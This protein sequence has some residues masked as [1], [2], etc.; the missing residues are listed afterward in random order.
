MDKKENLYEKFVKNLEEKYGKW[1]DLTSSFGHTKFG[2]IAEDLCVSSSQ[3][4]KLISGGATEGTYIRAIK[5][6]EQLK[7]LDSLKEENKSL[8]KE[9]D[10]LIATLKKPAIDKSSNLKYWILATLI[11]F[12]LGG[13]IVGSFLDEQSSSPNKKSNHFNHP[14]SKFFDKDFLAD[15]DSPYLNESEVQKYCPCSGYEGKWE[16]ASNYYFP[17][18]GSRKPGVYY[19]AKEGDIRLKCAKIMNPSKA[20]TNLIG[21]ERLLHEIWVDKRKR[22]FIP[23][24]FDPQSMTYTEA[25]KNL[26]FDTNPDFEKVAYIHSFFVDQFTLSSDSIYR[27]GEPCGRY[28]EIIN[29]ELVNE[30]ELDFKHLLNNVIGNLTHTNCSSSYNP[31]C[32]PNDLVEGESE[33]SFDCLFTI[34]TENLGIG[35]GYPYSKKYRLIEQNYSDNLLCGCKD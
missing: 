30:L 7:N 9:T 8:K 11:A 27:I 34:K 10:R 32:N 24:F 33:L 26:N 13:T 14:L 23:T 19:V 18:P 12:A 16:L 15:F 22:S 35:G 4:T 21:F 5:N 17:L 3:F 29:P 1:E 25:F 31:Y 28:A 2:K 20:G 6:V